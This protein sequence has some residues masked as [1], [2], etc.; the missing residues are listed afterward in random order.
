MTEVERT[1]EYQARNAHVEAIQ[2]NRIKHT[3][4]NGSTFTKSSNYI[5]F[6]L[7][8][9]G[10]FIDAPRTRLNLV[11]SAKSDVAGSGVHGVYTSPSIWSV[12]TSWEV[13]QGGNILERSQ[14]ANRMYTA[15]SKVYSST[16]QNET[17]G[18]ITDLINPPN[19]NIPNQCAVGVKISTGADSTKPAFKT[20]TIS[21]PI[22]LSNLFGPSARKSYPNALLR[23]STTIR[24][25]LTPNVEEVLYAMSVGATPTYDSAATYVLTDV[26]LEMVHIRYGP[27]VMSRIRDNM[28]DSEV[29][30]DGVQSISS[31]NSISYANT[32]RCILPNTSYSD[33]RNV[34]INQ[35]YPVL[36]SN[37][38]SMGCSPLNGTYQSQLFL[39]GNPIARNRPIG[40]QYANNPIASVPEL[41]QSV[42]DLNRPFCVV[43]DTNTQ[44]GLSRGNKTASKLCYTNCNTKGATSRP[45]EI[46]SSAVPIIS[47]FPLTAD[48]PVAPYF[49]LVGFNLV[50]NG[51]PSRASIGH[52]CRGRQ[53][54]YEARQ[55]N[56]ITDTNLCMVQ[57]IMC[58]G[59]KYV[60]DTRSGILRTIY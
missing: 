58:V 44:I 60:L 59:V 37:S 23:E 56:T 10:T 28:N 26:S 49:G 17:I 24:L 47:N 5:E 18:S 3:P 1:I 38:V 33:V 16:I 7:N 13:R 55:T 12:F 32:A 20:R 54:V 30:W 40:A 50:R 14:D 43:D 51:D 52:D 6:R 34:I 25:Y 48:T 21:V 41:A 46:P 22:T 42:L 27:D 29:S 39:D 8:N 31:I 45:Y 15:L 2:C 4:I 36:A 35:F 57:A 19:S 53:L 9:D 11:F